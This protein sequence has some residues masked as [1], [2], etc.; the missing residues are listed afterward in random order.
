[1]Q[2]NRN[3]RFMPAIPN[4]LSGGANPA[5][6]GTTMTAAVVIPFG[7]STTVLSLH[8]NLAAAREAARKSVWA[9]ARA[10]SV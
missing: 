3:G 7:D 4:P 10:V 5:L 1:M 9:D 2:R 6:T 8:P